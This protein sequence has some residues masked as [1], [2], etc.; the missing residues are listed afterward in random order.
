MTYQVNPAL[1]S[2]VFAIPSAVVDE[3]LRLC[4]GLAL[5]VLLWVLRH[6]NEENDAE[7]LSLSLKQAKSDVA[8]ALNYW[9]ENGVLQ[10]IGA[11]AV[12]KAEE[13]MA[14][15]EAK[16]SSPKTKPIVTR[17]GRP[18]FPRE[19]AIALAEAE[20]TL[21]SLL[22]EGQTIMGKAFTSA[23]L[24]SLAALFS[25]YGLSAHFILTAMHYCSSINKRSIGYVES[26]CVAW[27][28]DNVTDEN[29]GEYVDTLYKRDSNEGVIRREF[30]I[31]DRRLSAKERDYIAIW[32]E[33]YKTPLEL[34][35]LAYEKAVEN[36]GKLSFSYINTILTE[37]NKKQIDT[38]EKAM[39]AE[40]PRQ[41]GAKAKS[42]AN[43][44]ELTAR[45]VDEFMNG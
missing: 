22:D 41:R 14:G 10:K 24:D 30:G 15:P 8:D 42:A 32:F 44:E 7:A 37:W 34:I 36:T 35:S 23:D 6:P 29:I 4:S 9:E 17:T 13:K 11:P 33:Q 25:Y 2:G 45:L 40:L 12:V 20:P 28:N 19:E 26:V 3:H 16:V 43:T 27:L 5:K 1:W 39:E 38:V 21:A 31:G 18:H